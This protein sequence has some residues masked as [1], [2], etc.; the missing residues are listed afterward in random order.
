MSEK[1]GSGSQRGRAL[2]SGRCSTYR[3]RLHSADGDISPHPL[4]KLRR[5]ESPM[6]RPSR[7]LQSARH[8]CSGMSPEEV[9]VYHRFPVSRLRRTGVLNVYLSA[10]ST[11]TLMT[12]SEYHPTCQ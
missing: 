11:D 9:K 8:I 10:D 12:R 1:G 5:D 7:Q 2:Y 4:Q 6:K 3:W